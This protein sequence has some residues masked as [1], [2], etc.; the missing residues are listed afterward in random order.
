M[1]DHEIMWFLALNVSL[2]YKRTKDTIN[3]SM[4]SLSNPE[5]FHGVSGD[6]EV[7][8][9][10]DEASHKPCWSGSSKKHVV[11]KSPFKNTPYKQLAPENKKKTGPK[12]ET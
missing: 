2:T 10:H 6:V 11:S 8:H 1:N 5:M 12:K 4:A 7:T 3:A 9:S